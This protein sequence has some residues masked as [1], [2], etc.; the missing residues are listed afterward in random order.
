[1]FT[2]N[3]QG[4]IVQMGPSKT[5]N[6]MLTH[7]DIARLC[8]E[9]ADW[10]VARILA[11]EATYEDLKTAMAWAGGQ[12]DIVGPSG[13]PLTGLAAYL[14]EIIMADEDIWGENDTR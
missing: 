8:G 4:R 9:L 2:A 13:H 11:S 7:E 10:K 1:M 12:D 5:P 6:P 3:F 14:Y